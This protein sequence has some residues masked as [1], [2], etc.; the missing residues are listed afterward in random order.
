MYSQCDGKLAACSP[1]LHSGRSCDGYQ[2][3]LIF[4]DAVTSFKPKNKRRK[5]RPRS[6]LPDVP[7]VSEAVL[8]PC[9]TTHVDDML[10]RI[11]RSFIPAQAVAQTHPKSLAVSL[12][13]CGAWMER[14]S[15][16]STTG[17]QGKA[18]QASIKAS[19]MA[20]VSQRA[21]ATVS[22]VGALAAHGAA[23]RSV[24]GALRS[25]QLRKPDELS[26]A[27]M[28]LILSE[29]R[30]R[31]F[32]PESIVINQL[33]IFLKVLLPCGSSSESHVAGLM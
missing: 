32:V 7:T 15:E 29:V 30:T 4:V 18:L 9:L 26:A 23:L 33:L 21:L 27:I 5:K 11:A 13:V 10:S 24:H 20:I 6:T 19:A 25:S 14:V 3:D 22:T 8:S 28:F 17:H 1:C 16:L 2:Y 31:Q 12:R